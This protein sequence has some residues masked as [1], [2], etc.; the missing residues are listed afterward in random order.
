ML[1]RLFALT[2]LAA[3]IL[4]NPARADWI[5]LSGAEI[6]PNIAEVYVLDDR[7]KVVLEIYV[8]NLKSFEELIPDEWLK[9][10]NVSRKPVAERMRRFAERT[11]QVIGPDGKRLPA[12]LELVEPRLR[13]DRRSPFAG[14]VNPYTRQQVP[15][16]PADKRVLYAEISYPFKGHPAALTFVPPLDAAKRPVVSIGFIAYHKSVPVIDFRFLSA[17]ARL[18][19]NWRDPWYSK[20]DNPNLSRHHKDAL[21]SFLYVEPYEVRHEILVR[22]REMSNWMNLGLRGDK[23]IEV[24]ELEALKQ[25]IGEFLLR[26]NP[27]RVDGK[28]LTPILD[29]TNFVKI[30]LTGIQIIEAPERMEISSVII[31]VILTYLTEGMP[32]EVTVDWELFTDK[33]RR[34]PATAIDP[35]GPLPGFVEPRDRVLT[36]TNYL[37]N[38]KI[39]SVVATAVADTLPPINLPVGTALCVLTLMPLGWI[40]H[41]RRRSGH[42]TRALL[43]L[44]VALLVAGVGL[45]PYARVSLARPALLPPTLDEVSAEAILH[46]LLRNVYRSFDFRKESDVYDKLATSVAGDLLAD[47]YLQSRRSLLIEQAGGAQA[48]LQDIEILEALPEGPLDG[49]LAYD[50]RAKWTASGTVGH[51]GH[52]HLRKNLYEADL[53]IEGRD[54]IWKLTRVQLRDERR[55]DPAAQQAGAGGAGKTSAEPSGPTR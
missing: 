33:I 9:G 5:N 20:F 11:L 19:L 27:V 39:P 28:A 52:V 17:P 31:G 54:G 14:M 49:R 4:A 7:V 36:W 51:W 35:T 12:R 2:L 34:V 55:I 42:S 46:S 38:Y 50:V 23:Y 24:D 32:K 22:A 43:A 41:R 15:E 25:R 45:F 30:G 10:M 1:A 13:V 44:G 16:A 6:A 48:R 53:R 3:A 47:V 18:T 26:K 8:G 21:M 37:K 29:R 40:A